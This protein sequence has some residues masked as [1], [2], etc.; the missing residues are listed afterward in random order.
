MI[1]QQQ[2][3]TKI[4]QKTY[5]E[6]TLAKKNTEST[7]VNSNTNWKTPPKDN[8]CDFLVKFTHHFYSAGAKFATT[9]PPTLHF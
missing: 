6:I 1:S 3:P 7:Q 8:D 9:P 4:L 5:S 2:E